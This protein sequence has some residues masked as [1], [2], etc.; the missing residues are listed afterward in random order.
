M[1]RIIGRQKHWLNYFIKKPSNT[2]YYSLI[3][4]LMREDAPSRYREYFF[5]PIITEKFCFSAK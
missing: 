2:Q 5:I 3:V 4:L 1:D